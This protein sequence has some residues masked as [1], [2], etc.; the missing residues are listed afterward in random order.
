MDRRCRPLPIRLQQYCNPASLFNKK[1]CLLIFLYFIHL[2]QDKRNQKCVEY[3][4]LKFKQGRIHSYPSCMRWA[5]AVIDKV[6][7]AFGQEQ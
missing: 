3:H 7:R 6:R 1:Y 5:G 2:P 4:E